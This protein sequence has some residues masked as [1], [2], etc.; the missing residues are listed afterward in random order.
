MSIETSVDRGLTLRVNQ[1]RA[2]LPLW[3]SLLK[4]I[5]VRVSTFWLHY[6]VIQTSSLQVEKAGLKSINPDAN[7]NGFKKLFIMGF[8]FSIEWL[9][10]FLYNIFKK[11]LIPRKWKTDT[12]T[13]NG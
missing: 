2:L 5:F 13:T 11:P 7:H 6:I 8:E 1:M 4:R 12:I 9:Q 3:Q 10:P